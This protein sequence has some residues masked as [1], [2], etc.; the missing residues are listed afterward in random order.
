ML[1]S[2][3][4]DFY[5]HKI[6][7][8]IDTYIAKPLHKLWNLKL[9]FINSLNSSKFIVKNISMIKVILFKFNPDKFWL[10]NDLVKGPLKCFYNQFTFVWS[11]SKTWKNTTLLWLELFR[12]SL[13]RKMLTSKSAVLFRNNSGLAVRLRKSEVSFRKLRSS[14]RNGR[15]WIRHPV[16]FFFLLKF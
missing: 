12:L 10:L 4:T 8:S 11:P 1:K 13:T 15:T 5:F 9:G 16:R 3:S 6:V 7:R 14:L 2:L